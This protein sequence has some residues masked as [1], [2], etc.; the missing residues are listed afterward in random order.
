MQRKAGV[1]LV[2]VLL[3]GVFTAVATVAVS[4]FGGSAT[5]PAKLP[6]AAAT[7][8][9]IAAPLLPISLD[10]LVFIAS[11]F[12]PILAARRACIPSPAILRQLD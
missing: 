12:A 10:L 11:P 9:A 5:Q 1:K 6:T 4:G 2:T 7:T 3:A 8:A